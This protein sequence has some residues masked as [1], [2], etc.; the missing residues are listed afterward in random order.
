MLECPS[1][2]HTKF[3]VK[4]VRNKLGADGLT[5]LRSCVKCGRDFRTK[6]IILSESKRKPKFEQRRDNMITGKK[7]LE[8]NKPDFEKMTDE[9]LE[10]YIFSESAKFDDEEL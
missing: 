3:T 9:E 2:K 4:N 6:E 1:C 8:K 7:R 10:D 5:R